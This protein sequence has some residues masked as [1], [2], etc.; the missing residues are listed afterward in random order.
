MI[1]GAV[2]AIFAIATAG[3]FVGASYKLINTTAAEIEVWR[4]ETL[5]AISTFGIWATRLSSKIYI[6]NLHLNTDAEERVTMI[7]TYLALLRDG[8]GPKDEERQLILQTLFRPSATGYIKD[9]G[10]SSFIDIA[11]SMLNRQ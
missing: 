8:S 2:T 3:V 10:P 11:N 4:L 6:S 5:L 7:Q 9:D 1:A